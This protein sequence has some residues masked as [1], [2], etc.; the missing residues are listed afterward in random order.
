MSPKVPTYKGQALL[1]LRGIVVR[2]SSTFNYKLDSPKM[3]Q[4]SG[5][6]GPS[7]QSLTMLDSWRLKERLPRVQHGQALKLCPAMPDPLMG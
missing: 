3:A 2:V 7:S 1:D 5:N 4:E 6:A